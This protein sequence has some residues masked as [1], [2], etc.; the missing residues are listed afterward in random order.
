MNAKKIFITV[1]GSGLALGAPIVTLNGTMG[2]A[3]G[4]EQVEWHNPG[5]DEAD[6]QAPDGSFPN[7]GTC[8]YFGPREDVRPIYTF[9]DEFQAMRKRTADTN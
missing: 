9:A 7:H 5:I 4:D 2:A 1:I 3:V 8:T 6:W